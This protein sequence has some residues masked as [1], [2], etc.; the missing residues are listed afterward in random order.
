MRG[1]TSKCASF[2]SL[3]SQLWHPVPSHPSLPSWG[4]LR[5]FSAG[6][7]SLC[8]SLLWSRQVG[9][10]PGT[11]S[12]RRVVSSSSPSHPQPHKALAVVP[13]PP[14]PHLVVRVRP[15]WAL[16][17][18]DPRT[19]PVLLGRVLHA[20]RMPVLTRYC[21]QPEA[22]SDF[23]GSAHGPILL[24]F[25]ILGSCRRLHPVCLGARTARGIGGVGWG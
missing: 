13:V 16:T 15:G 4:G 24:I 1:F 8:A 7:T 11:T 2:P 17:W 10:E 3:Q 22:C 20:S 5:Q 23:G 12:C 25:R 6:L 18:H 9:E 19:R 14:G 21:L